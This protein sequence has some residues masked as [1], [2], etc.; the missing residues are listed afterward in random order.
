[1]PKMTSAGFAALAHSL[2]EQNSAVAFF[3]DA[4]PT[5]PQDQKVKWNV[6]HNSQILQ[7]VCDQFQP[8]FGDFEIETLGAADAEEMV[9]LATLTKPG[10]FGLRTHEMGTFLGVR[11]EGK[12]V[13]MA[14]QR[15]HLDGFIEVSGV[16][17]HPD[18]AGRGYAGVLVSA[19]AQ[20]IIAEG[21]TPF[22][23]SRLDNAGAIALYEKLG[24][25]PR[26]EITLLIVKPEFGAPT[27]G[28][29]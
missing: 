4:Q 9:A 22:L 18:H 2:A 28:A 5:I 8:R 17:T 15:L 16:C 1:M 27:A 21:L 10:P 13:A 7:M 25:A 19:V 24:F 20:Q 11:K 6:I 29:S 3:L 12:I 14:G 23:H 26:R